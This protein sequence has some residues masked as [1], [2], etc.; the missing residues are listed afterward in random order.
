MAIEGKRA[1]RRHARNSSS[2]KLLLRIEN[3]RQLALELPLAPVAVGL[4]DRTIEI[5]RETPKKKRRTTG[6]AAHRLVE[7]GL[8]AKGK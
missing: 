5:L 6:G 4:L 3:Y 8:K 7:I 1:A 2:D